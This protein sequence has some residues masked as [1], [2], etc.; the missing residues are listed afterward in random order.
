MKVEGAGESEEQLQRSTKKVKTRDEGGDF[1]YKDSLMNT[2]VFNND[3][4]PFADEA[5]A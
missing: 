5:Y 2:S 4:S 1:S 3:E